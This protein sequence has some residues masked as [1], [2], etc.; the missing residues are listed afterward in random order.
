MRLG[1]LRLRNGLELRQARASMAFEG[2]KLQVRSFTTNLLGGSAKGTMRFEGRKKDVRVNFE[3]TGLLL[4]RWFKDR[5]RE[6]AFTGGAMAITASLGATGDSLRDLAK[7]ITGPVTIRMGP[8]AYASQKAGDAEAMMAVFSKKDSTGRIAFECAGADLPFMQGRA[9]RDAI[10]GARSDVS[11]L[12]TSGYVSLRDEAVDLHGRVRP[13]PGM[14]VGLSSIVGD[15]R[16]AGKMRALK[17]TLDPA[18]KPG[19]ALRAGA[20]IATLG[21]SL[22]GSAVANAARED[23]DPCEAVFANRR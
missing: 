1:S 8:G 18:G 9:T 16:I 6:I 15:I 2:D 10:V 3:G 12:L 13:K 14:G 22:A 7:S 4:E 23:V 19:A 11:R 17:V 5:G 20:A 21:L